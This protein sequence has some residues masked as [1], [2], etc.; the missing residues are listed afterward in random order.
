MMIW[1]AKLFVAIALSGCVA[2]L[3]SCQISGD[4]KTESGGP[5]PAELETPVQYEGGFDS[6]AITLEKRA[7]LSDEAAWALA[8]CDCNPGRFK[9][10]F[11]SVATGRGVLPQILI[12]S[13]REDVKGNTALQSLQKIPI[14]GLLADFFA[15]DEKLAKLIRT[16]LAEKLKKT[17]GGTNVAERVAFRFDGF[18]PKNNKK[19]TFDVSEQLARWQGVFAAD[20]LWS[21]GE[22]IDGTDHGLQ[23]LELLRTL[24]EWKY[25]IGLD[26]NTDGGNYGGLTLSNADG[27]AKLNGPIDPRNKKTAAWFISGSYSI[28]YDDRSSKEL[29]TSVKEGWKHG[30]EAVALDEQARLWHTAALAFK[31][32]RPENRSKISSMFGKA[33]EGLLP[34]EAHMLPL[35]FL[36]G[37]NVLLPGPFIDREARLIRTYASLDGTGESAQAKMVTVSRLC[38]ALTAW[39]T[40]LK[41]VTA[42]IVDPETFRRVEAAPAGLLPALQLAVQTILSAHTMS[43]SESGASYGLALHEAGVRPDISDASETLVG[44]MEAESLLLASDFLHERILQIL[45]WYA[46]DL[47]NQ[48][49]KVTE[50]E[51]LWMRTVAVHANEFAGDRVAGWAPAVIKFADSALKD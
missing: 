41:T 19:N 11:E 16:G 30:N 37:M 17:P 31:R 26:A 13:V 6:S 40:E 20:G 51:L 8:Q 15:S 47:L 45:D 34:P 29:A 7:N 23:V 3:M 24:A 22:K 14:G 36:T 28:S 2:G 35:A 10:F 9:T 21:D 46:G 18:S 48:T 32:L 5:V 39:I 33:P 1:S 27:T 50:K 43:A 42:P 38:R 4:K 49:G 12:P 25:M 44:L